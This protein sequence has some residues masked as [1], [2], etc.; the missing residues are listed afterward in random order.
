SASAVAPRDVV[1]TVIEPDILELTPT[2]GTRCPGVS[3]PSQLRLRGDPI[4]D[5]EV[6]VIMAPSAISTPATMMFTTLNAQTPQYVFL[7]G[8]VGRGSERFEFQ[9][10]TM[11][12]ITP[13]AANLTVLSP[14]AVSCTIVMQ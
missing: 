11:Q 10:P 9:V 14:T 5:L 7:Q 8:N 12:G 1:V 2:T 3:L 4:H 13:V 6:A